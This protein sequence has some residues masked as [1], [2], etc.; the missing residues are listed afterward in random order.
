MNIKNLIG[1]FLASATVLIVPGVAL[2][3]TNSDSRAN[4]GN[5]AVI[6]CMKTAVSTR[7]TSLKSAHAAFSVAIDGAYTARESALSAAWSK[8]SWSEIKPSIR[9]AW[10]DFKDATKLGKR[11]WQSSKKET[12]K[13]F[14]T[15]AKS[16]RVPSDVNDSGNSSADE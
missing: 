15:D 11:T 2:A 4:A 9:T 1:V 5:P 7:E 6:A 10:K 13:K 12:W 14:K 3:R 8:S 16:C